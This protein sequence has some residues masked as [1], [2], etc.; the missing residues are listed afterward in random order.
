[1]SNRIITLKTDDGSI[2]EEH[3]DLEKEFMELYKNML[4]E[5]DDNKGEAIK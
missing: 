1:M 5:P 3:A 4:T 2:L